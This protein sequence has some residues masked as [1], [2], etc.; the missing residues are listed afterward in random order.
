MSMEL[1]LKY[2]LGAAHAAQLP[3]L[4]QLYATVHNS[5]QQPLLNAY[6]DTHDN[7]FRRHDMGLRTRQKRGQLEQTVKLAGQQHGALQMRP[8]YNVPCADIV[9][10]LAHFPT[11]IWPDDTDVVL[12]QQQLVELF[13]TDFMRQSWHISVTNAELEVV[14]DNGEVRAGE[15][16]QALSELEIELISGDPLALFALADFLLKSLPM[17]TGWLS[18]AARGYQLFHNVTTPRPAA[19][20]TFNERALPDS[21]LVHLQR[22]QQWEVCYVQ[23]FSPDLLLAAEQELQMLAVAL[24]DDGQHLLASD[25]RA[26]ARKLH[27]EGALLF[28]SQAY[29]QLVLQISASLFKRA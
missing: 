11:E 23:E 21:V 16:R 28:N 26:L 17:R 14:Y 18:K 8:E 29:Q 15:R 19:L 22:V 12:L 9:P 1:E 25:T 24:L 20:S 3:E 7:W 2:L 27:D 5:Q 13:R 10:N 6:F 4:L